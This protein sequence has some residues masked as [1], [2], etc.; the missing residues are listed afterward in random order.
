MLNKLSVFI[1][2]STTKLPYAAK[3]GR[4]KYKTTASMAWQTMASHNN[5]K[6]LN[7]LH[8]AHFI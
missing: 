3:K 5:I 2:L 1:T 4:N 6:Y 8:T 7:F